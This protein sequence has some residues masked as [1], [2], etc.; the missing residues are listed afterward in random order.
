MFDNLGI[1]FESSYGTRKDFY[2]RASDKWT[3]VVPHHRDE[4]YM[5]WYMYRRE[6]DEQAK[7]IFVFISHA[8]T[9]AVA[10]ATITRFAV[11]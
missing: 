3:S 5:P 6:M 1:S 11:L 8:F 9:Y 7:R 10:V 4:P 2:E